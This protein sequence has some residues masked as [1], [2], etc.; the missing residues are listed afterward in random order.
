MRTV[1]NVLLWPFKM[2]LVLLKAFVS[3]LVGG[4]VMSVIMVPMYTGIGVV[5]FKLNPNV[6]LDQIVMYC[7]YTNIIVGMLVVIAAAIKRK[8]YIAIATIIFS[9]VSILFAMYPVEALNFLASHFD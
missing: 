4:W 3:I 7:I 6:T 5:A 8:W 1:I 9:V 2:V